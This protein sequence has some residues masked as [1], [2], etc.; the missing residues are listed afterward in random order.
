MGCAIRFCSC[1]ENAV[2]YLDF[3]LDVKLILG[4]E[5]RMS[6]AGFSREQSKLKLVISR[7]STDPYSCPVLQRYCI[8]HLR[9]VAVNQVVI[10]AHSYSEDKNT[11]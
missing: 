8:I 3:G 4:S 2:S 10:M 1:Y 9:W 7:I 5:F 11:Y 6:P